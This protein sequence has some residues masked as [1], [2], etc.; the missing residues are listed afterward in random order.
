MRQAIITTELLAEEGHLEWL[1]LP[2]SGHQDLHQHFSYPSSSFYLHHPMM[3]LIMNS[4]MSSQLRYS[5]SSQVKTYTLISLSLFSI[6]WQ[7]RG[8]SS[9]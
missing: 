3:N 4:Q 9:W 5:S 7:E 1:F 8:A 6:E 2:F